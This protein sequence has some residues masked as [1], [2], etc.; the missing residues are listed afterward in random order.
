MKKG[1]G[2]HTAYLEEMWFG[3]Q[4]CTVRGG[5]RNIGVVSW[6]FDA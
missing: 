1:F 2:M 5:K 4:I 3:K 6:E